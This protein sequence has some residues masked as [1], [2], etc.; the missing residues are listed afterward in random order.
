MTPANYNYDVKIGY[1][2]DLI[3]TGP[4][5]Q[6]FPNCGE[7]VITSKPFQD[8]NACENALSGLMSALTYIET[9]FS[10]KNHVIVTKINPILDNSGK[11]H[12]DADTWDKH[13]VMRAYVAD[14]EELKKAT[15]NYHVFGQIRVDQI[16]L[17]LTA[18]P[19]EPK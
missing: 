1:G 10:T 18:K 6:S 16:I 5:S 12:A 3:K 9:K 7:L 8:Y 14:S 19:E 11:K 4:L 15:L 17:G 2:A 13:T